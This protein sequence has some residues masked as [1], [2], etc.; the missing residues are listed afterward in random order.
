MWLS[1][2]T[3]VSCW[4]PHYCFLNIHSTLFNTL[5]LFCWFVVANKFRLGNNAF[6]RKEYGPAFSMTA[7]KHMYLISSKIIRTVINSIACIPV[8][9]P[10]PTQ[11]H[12]S[13]RL[14]MHIKFPFL[15][16]V[17]PEVYH[18]PS[19]FKF[20]IHLCIKLIKRIKM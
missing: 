1:V 6:Q 16:N 19:P 12:P 13:V 14:H 10:P 15:N 4:I 18:I 5:H 9:K 17:C 7:F 2:T 3:H 11:L 20:N 8:N